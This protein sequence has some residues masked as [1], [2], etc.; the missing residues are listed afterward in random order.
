MAITHEV[1]NI[2]NF[3]KSLSISIDDYLIFFHKP[4]MTVAIYSNK[5][6]VLKT[7]V[8]DFEKMIVAR[9]SSGQSIGVTEDAVRSAIKKL[10]KMRSFL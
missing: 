4:T 9:L 5:L 10:L 7:I 3:P 1:F 8:P 2:V 6:E